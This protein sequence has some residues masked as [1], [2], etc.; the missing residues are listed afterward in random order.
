MDIAQKKESNTEKKQLDNL[1]NQEETYTF[2]RKVS[3]KLLFNKRIIMEMAF[4]HI[5]IKKRVF[6]PLSII[7]VFCFLIWYRFPLIGDE[8][9]KQ[10]IYVGVL[11]ALCES[12]S[13]NNAH[14]MWI[15]DDSGEGVFYVKRIAK[16]LSIQPVFAVI[17]DK[18]EPDIAD[19]LITWQRE[20]AGFVLHGLRHEHWEEWNK[21]QIEQDII[22]SYQRLHQI[23]FDTAHILKIIIPPYGANTS[24]IRQV[25]NQKGCQMISGASLVN[26]NRHAFQLGRIAI[27]P[28]TDIEKTNR[29]LQKAFE[30]KAF[31]IFST[32]SSMPSSFS[33]EKTKDILKKAKEI[34]FIIDN[35]E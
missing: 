34:G 23:G 22:Q 27:T 6:V 35:Y 25:I 13:D 11:D 9:N 28:Q 3:L 16:E 15:D 19:S 29:L 30:Q 21:V 24:A 2:A 17:A 8:I 5:I 12:S 32:H 1:E 7:I 4:I 10:T 14:A 26:P 18:M 31:I 20:G 33:F